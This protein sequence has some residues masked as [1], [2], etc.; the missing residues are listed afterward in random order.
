M[1]NYLVS[2]SSI[3]VPPETSIVTAV[4]DEKVDP[5]FAFVASVRTLEFNPNVEL[6]STLS[7]DF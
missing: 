7:H 5:N 3:Q 2:I 4:L 6:L 1:I